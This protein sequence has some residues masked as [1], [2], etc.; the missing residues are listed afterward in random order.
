[1]P[2]HA[3]TEGPGKI[4]RGGLRLVESPQINRDAVG[5]SLNTCELICRAQLIRTFPLSHWKTSTTL[6]AIT[7]T[8]VIQD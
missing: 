5:Y 6:T 7:A 3:A 2:I 1:M 4:K 8:C